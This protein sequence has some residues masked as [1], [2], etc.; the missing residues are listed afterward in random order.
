MAKEGFRRQLKQEAEQWQ[1]EG[2]IS[3][4]LFQQ[5]ADRY[6]F[7]T[8][9]PNNQNFT[10]ILYSV[11][12]ILI[13]LG[14]ITFVAANW[15]G[16][17][18]NTKVFLLFSWLIHINTIGFHF[19]Q[20][21][22]RF[23]RIGQGLLLMG[24]LSLGAVIALISQTF[25]LSGP[26]YGLFLIWAVGVIVMGTSLEFQTLT[27]LGLILLGIGYIGYTRYT[28]YSDLYEKEF[29]LIASSMPYLSIL[30]IG[31]AYWLKSRAVFVLV[32]L[33]W[34]ISIFENIWNI[35]S[36]LS[37]VIPTV[38]L[39]GYDETLKLD[40]LGSFLGERKFEP[41]ARVISVLLGTIVLYI[42]SFRYWI[43]IQPKEA[44]GLGEQLYFGLMAGISF[45]LLVSQFFL[46]R[47]NL[48][49]KLFLG[50]IAVFSF[51]GLLSWEET[52]HGLFIV[53]INNCLLAILSIGLIRI[54][55]EQAHRRNFWLGIIFLC[56]QIMSRTFEY[57][58]DLL[59]KAFMFGLCGIGILILGIWFE[60]YLQNLS[61]E[62][63]P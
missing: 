20:R 33:L 8:L 57:D 10:V 22:N 6:E 9:A 61:S 18:R 40:R 45:Y 15:K 28:N 3:A 38:I 52:D 32:V 42:Y 39:W 16:L 62:A 31:L 14:V 43:G 58:T 34:I 24:G 5:I 49:A 11:A 35:K 37:W 2:L 60:R 13:G 54:G 53:L 51:T 27:M 48:N 1:K 29:N 55:I 7:N 30:L 56:L 12:G 46:V 59:F 36:H 47:N 17:D 23:K 19:W 44:I 26:W 25:H 4:D 21:T 63:N 41:I 50:I